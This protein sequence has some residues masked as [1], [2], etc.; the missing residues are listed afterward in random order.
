MVVVAVNRRCQ[1]G[2]LHNGSFLRPG[3]HL[4]GLGGVNPEPSIPLPDHDPSCVA[5]QSDLGGI[6]ARS[7]VDAAQTRKDDYGQRE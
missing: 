1:E 2:S 4:A 5:R 3:Q 7:G 6:E